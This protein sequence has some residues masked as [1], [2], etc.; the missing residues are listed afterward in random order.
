MEG[1]LL[2]TLKPETLSEPE[3]R[4]YQD[5]YEECR[6]RCARHDE[7]G[8]PIAEY[9]PTAGFENAYRAGWK[10]ASSKF[11]S[12]SVR[13]R[14]GVA[15]DDRGAARSRRLLWLSVLA[16]LIA[17]VSAAWAVWEGREG[18]NL[19]TELAVTERRCRVA[20]N[21]WITLGMRRGEAR[22]DWAP[23]ESGPLTEYQ[24]QL[25]A[26]ET[27]LHRWQKGFDDWRSRAE[28][29]AQKAVADCRAQRMALGREVGAHSLQTRISYGV[30]VLMAL[31]GAGL[32]LRR[33]ARD[34]AQGQNRTNILSGP[35][36]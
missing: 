13:R 31:A 34:R 2:D 32:L 8:V 29:D 15:A 17:A 28:A 33:G 14:A 12:R 25:K 16:L 20:E 1:I 9:H 11:E 27:G 10:Q 19:K 26:W 24:K 6:R 30:S 3:R 36:P 7:V 18:A 4:A 21:Y 22:T 35:L 23:A 5:G